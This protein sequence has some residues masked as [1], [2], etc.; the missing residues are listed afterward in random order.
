[1]ATK[2][3]SSTAPPG[4]FRPFVDA[5]EN[6]REFSL[7]AV[8]LG[9][10]FGI[11][12]GAVS[13]YVGLRAGLTVSA[14][15]PI[16]VLSISILRAFGRSTI[17][18]NNIVQTTGSAGESAAAGVIFTMPAL[19][20]LGYSLN[21]EYWRIFFLA[22]L[23]GTLGVL[24]MIPLRRQLIV[25]EHGNLTFPEGT[26]C[27]DVLVAGERGGSFAGRV[28]WGLGLGGVYTFCMNTLGMWP[29]QPDYQPKWLPGASMRCTITSEYLGVGYIIGPRVAGTLF[30]GGVISW[31][32]MM[33]AIRFFGSLAPGVALYPSTIPIPQMSP[34]QLWGTYIRPMGAGAV[35][36][37]GLITLIKTMPTILA[38]LTAGLKDVRAKHAAMPA[39]SRTERDLSMRV[40]IVGSVVIMAMIWALLRFK[41]IPGAQSGAFANLIA[42]FFIIVFGFLFVTVASRISGL[43]GNSS[44][45]ISGMTIATLMA[46]C[47]VFLVVHWTANSYAVLALT[48]GGVVCIAAAI[49]GATSQDLKTGYL[50][51]ATPAKQ[52]IGL[53]IGVLVSSFA[54]GGTL[55]LMNVGLA[56][57]K[58]IQ[59]ALDINQLPTG[60]EKQQDNYTHEGK[61]YVLVNAIGSGEI[62][63]GKY[64][65]DPA[66]RQIE[67]QWEQGIGSAKAAA[68][69]AR[70][71][72]TV[73]SGIL[74]RRLPWRLVFLGV[75]LVIAIE[76]LGVRSLPFAVGSYISIGTTMAMFAG[77][78]VRWLAERGA[79]KKEG[80]ESE[81]SPGSLYSSGLIAAG[82]VFGLLAI[83]IN[84]LQDQELSEHLPH[85][86]IR[87]LHL[88]WPTGMF[89]FG[90]TFMPQLSQK[91]G[92]GVFLFVAL[93]IT[94]FVSAR[95]KLKQS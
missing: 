6:L 55:I 70:L 47:A 86:L 39:A 15:I 68:P 11:L 71:M 72:A 83:V 82:G 41:P 92:L 59:I 73:I 1:M 80:A 21:T 60:V 12:F 18:E 52:Q 17:L 67:V 90:Q 31:L 24:F 89:A 3:W 22:L 57:Y 26:A 10:L 33:P 58:P 2:A 27:A 44:N 7:R 77:G 78:L 38:A 85:W 14:S 76:I 32:V 20:F 84:L 62:P 29:T 65:Y 30:A 74:N 81:V 69:Q 43:I 9:A 56:Q 64:L 4:E 63:D 53:V 50:V 5:G 91:M 34:D 16:A 66:T 88:P 95:K 46:T 19:I 8:V 40:V 28:F 87:T 54:I 23:G 61:T 79:E 36:A 51:G 94:L 49:A 48:I 13:V 42:A 25:K 37:S 75:F 35:A 45:P 93:A